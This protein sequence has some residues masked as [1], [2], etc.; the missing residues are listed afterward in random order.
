MSYIN[1]KSIKFVIGQIIRDDL[2]GHYVKIKRFKGDKKGVL[3][4]LDNKE[5]IKYNKGLRRLWE[6]TCVTKKEIY[7]QGKT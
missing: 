1:K 6:I 2:I 5:S 4:V 7:M 3:L